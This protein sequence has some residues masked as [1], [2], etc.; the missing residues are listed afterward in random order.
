MTY[1]PWGDIPT[2]FIIIS[3]KS[4]RKLSDADGF[5]GHLMLVGS[6]IAKGLELEQGF[7]VVINNARQGVQS[8]HHLQLH[9][10][11]GRMFKWP[12]G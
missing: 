12:P 5:L 6:K 8:I 1:H 4:I 9:F 11:G 10:L 7:R 3:N 2:H